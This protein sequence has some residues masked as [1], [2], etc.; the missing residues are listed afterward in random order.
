M[1]IALVH[2]YFLSDSGSGV[3]VRELAKQF[4]RAGH[5]VTLVCQEPNPQNYGFI[6][7]FYEMKRGNA[8][9]R[10]VFTRDKPFAGSCRMIRPDIKNRLLTYVASSS[11]AFQNSTFQETPLPVIEDYVKSNINALTVIFKQW[12]QDFIQTNHAIM[13]PYETL[14]ALSDQTPYCVTI[15][16]S[17]LNFSVKADK[18]LKRYF[19]EGIKG[20]AS[21]VALSDDSAHDVAQ[22]AAGLGVD[23]SRKVTVIPPGVDTSLF[24]PN[25]DGARTFQQLFDPFPDG[26]VAVQAGRLLWTKG[27]HYT[28]AAVPLISQT[29]RDF[30]LILAGDGPME[31]PLREFI[32]Y[33][34]QG[35]V[36]AAR[37]HARDSREMEE[38]SQ[39]GPVVPDFGWE[40]EEFYAKAAAGNTKKRIHFTGHISHEELAPLVGVADVVLMP[41][42]FPEA[43]GLSAIEGLSAG[44]LP[45]A[46]YH[47]GLMG[48]LSII[49]K[50]ISDP[51]IS[52]IIPGV[53]LTRALADGVTHIT[54]RYPT[55]DPEFRAGLHKLAEERF[56]WART[57]ETYIMLFKE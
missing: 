14:R 20:A 6:D 52:S 36:S 18:R 17:A 27:V 9:T 39:Y 37:Q 11:P 35:N 47:S 23:I 38:S 4:T 46:A 2:G 3:Y 34:D 31:T 28:A 30:N 15:H 48:P 54:D 19:T 40:E 42:V 22:Y 25:P 1:R 32:D 53:G 55:Q 51:V 10:N 45:V 57:A 29:G 33:L 50:K 26:A 5:D 41:S 7:T 21:V 56:S 49:A 16:G 24:K 43:Y 12:P 8:S 44:A 13:Q